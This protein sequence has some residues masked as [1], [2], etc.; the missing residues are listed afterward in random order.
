[1]KKKPLIFLFLLTF[2][3]FFQAS[4]QRV[5]WTEGASSRIRTGVLTPTAITSPS[6]FID[7]VSSPSKL[8]VD[9][10]NNR[11]HYS[12]WGLA[13]IY[14]ANLT[15]GGYVSTVITRGAMAEFFDFAN[16][17]N[18]GGFFAPNGPEIQGVTFIPLNNNNSGSESLLNLPGFAD[19]IFSAV[20][21]DDGNE[22]VYLASY[23]DGMLYRTGF[24][25]G[26]IEAVQNV[27]EV[28]TM[29]YDAMNNHL[30]YVAYNSGNIIYR[31]NLNTNATSAVVNTGFSE[32]NTV[33]VYPKLGKIYYSVYNT[34]IYSIN[35]DGTGLTQMIALGGA[36]DIYFDIA[37]DIQPPLYT[38]FSPAANAT[39]VPT[40]VSLSMTFNENIKVSPSAGTGNELT[41]R[42]MRADNTLHHSITRASTS[43]SIINNVMT[44][45]GIP[46]LATNSGYYVLI[47]GK[48]ISDLFNNDFAGISGTTVWA[49][50]TTPGV[51]PGPAEQSVC[52]GQDT[53]IQIVITESSVAD[54]KTGT[55]QSLTLSLLTPGY[56]FE[57]G[58]VIATSTGD[59]TV[60]SVILFGSTLTINYNAAGETQLDVLTL[61]G[62]PVRSDNSVAGWTPTCEFRRSGG[63]AVITGLDDNT[64]V[65]TLKS[66]DTP[67]V[68]EITYPNGDQ[69]CLNEDVA[70]IIVNS[71]APVFW[72]SDAQL[73]NQVTTTASSSVT[74][75]DLQIPNS[76]VQTYSRYAVS[77]LN[78]CGSAPA[79]AVIVFNSGPTTVTIEKTDV[80]SCDSDNGSATVTAVDGGG[81]E[82]YLYAWYDGAMQP[83]GVTTASVSNL[84]P[85][86]YIVEVTD[87]GTG[88]SMY[89]EISILDARSIPALSV[90]SEPN[91][92]CAKIANGSAT[93]VPQG[94][95]MPESEYT[96]IWRSGD[97][98]D[99]PVI[100]GATSATITG[101]AA[102]MYNVSIVHIDTRCASAPYVVEVADQVTYPTVTAPS[103]VVCETVA[104][105]ASATVDLTTYNASIIGDQTDVEVTWYDGNT[106][107][108]TLSVQSGKQL[109]IV[110]HHLISECTS[111]QLV[112][113]TVESQ[114]SQANAG[115]DQEFCGSTLVLAA[116]T[117][118]TGSGT[119][120][121]LSGTGGTVSNPSSAS[122]SFSG[123][124]GNTYVLEWT[125]TTNAVCPASVD[126][127]TIALALP[128]TTA[129]AGDDQEGCGNT[130]TLAGNTPAS[131][132]GQWSV[133]SGTGG[134]ISDPALPTSSFSGMSGTTYTLQWT[135]TN[136]NCTPSSDQVI[137]TFPAAPSVA[138]AGTDISNCGTTVSL[139]ANTPSVGSGAW[140]V[141]SGSGGI[142]ASPGD[143]SSS[144]TGLTGTTYVLQW[145]ITNGTCP[146]STDE[147]QVQFIAS[148]TPAAAGDD[149][150]VCGTTAALAAN[151]PFTG[152]GTWSVI[153]GTGGSVATPESPS[154]VFSGTAGNTYILRW[155]I[156]NGDCPITEDDV[157]I[158]LV[159]PP[160]VAAAGS[161]QVACSTNATLAANSPVTGTGVWSI[162]SG[163][164]GVVS[165]PANPLSSFTGTSGVPYVLRWTISNGICPPSTDEVSITVVTPPT[166]ADAGN[167]IS[168]CGTS[169]QLAANTPAIG[170]GSWSVISGSGGNVSA[171]AS[172]AS[173]FNGIAG[174]TYTLRWTISQNGCPASTDDAVVQLKSTPS[175]TGIMSPVPPICT[176]DIATLTL[177]GISNATSFNWQ[178]P[179]GIV[180]E[181]DNGASIGIRAMS[182][183][184]GTVVVT[185]SNECGTSAPVNSNV[186]VLP[187]PEVSIN[188]PA[189][190]F[191]GDPAFFSFNSSAQIQSIEWDFG[192]GGGSSAATVEH[193][194]AA[195]G[196]Y[197]VT[198]AVTASNGCEN[199]DTKVFTVFAEPDLDAFAIKNVITANGD[200]KNRVLYIENLDRHPENEVRFLDRWGVE[201]FST[202][203]YGNDW[204]AR[205]KD[206]HFLPAGQYI[207]IVRIGS[208]KVF[209]RT[210]SIIKG[211]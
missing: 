164:G 86:N 151:T 2:F 183:S 83:L 196:D 102:G 203:N 141:T 55:N 40:N 58:S 206:G 6:A 31:L 144:F 38:A 176:G 71:S 105:S 177:T 125:V 15:N 30:Y 23:D 78:E 62:I 19:A 98:P 210:V 65:T 162:I 166:A 200:D 13:D 51:V 75:A 193:V 205:G 32:V 202:R 134:T 35:L 66:L 111:D 209:S 21:V 126:N 178:V 152:S 92:S 195:G 67:P 159:V 174:N 120:S 113:F 20:A 104:G 116:E 12:T 81:P 130:V 4:S 74:G 143:P 36:G 47:G 165:D 26:W 182:G 192:D 14:S 60:Q 142:L 190:A 201:V 109:Q 18:A 89:Q 17:D 149:Q 8:E 43:I 123:V 207:C 135:I 184:G 73:T 95:T 114:P 181:S 106:P 138:N 72:Y 194:F 24:A 208:G 199:S 25:G 185:A 121:I 11:L 54:I 168:V 97:Q 172:P 41:V 132:T 42:I 33:Q 112:I 180:I 124:T 9:Q 155:T 39:N 163:A 133:V 53:E 129:I 157:Q 119:W 28:R 57:V 197:P 188:L 96:Y 145:S 91:T 68:P 173:A 63:S 128:P 87:D 118:A 171:P 169:T 49:F 84:A 85:G 69:F 46:E 127:V 204:E 140:I 189:S 93:A 170:T 94:V 137:I 161:D 108:T 22:L 37:R 52:T 101:L 186:S 100:D 158:A 148:P 82:K 50:T 44:I 147:V 110:V 156:T 107:V 187:L 167:D 80:T 179:A 131:G 77:Y 64:L 76:V 136:G 175:G 70:N 150:E 103:T 198:V 56:T 160:T 3:A 48:V 79:E 146:P 154:S 7:N 88:C 34:A 45:T 1:M 59:V 99:S 153:G 5:Y 191:P 139:A 27:G 10:I 29:A 61:T 16:S 211:R 117:P 90:S 115:Q 122:S